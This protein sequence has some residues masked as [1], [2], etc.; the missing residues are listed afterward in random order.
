MLPGIDQ[1]A[2]SVSSLLARAFF[3]ALAYLGFR[4]LVA[5]LKPAE[6]LAGLGAIQRA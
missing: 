3:E 6:E 1:S 4:L 2:D 5:E